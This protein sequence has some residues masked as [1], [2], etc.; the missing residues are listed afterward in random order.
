MSPPEGTAIMSGDVLERLSSMLI[1]PVIEIDDADRAAPLADAL[2]AAGLPCAEVTFRTPAAAA[3]IEA[4]AARHPDLL[5][6][7]GTVLSATQADRAL[8]CGAQF[9]VSPGCNPEVVRHA[10]VMGAVMLPGVCT[11]TEVE[12]ALALGAGVLKFFPAGPVGGPAYLKALTAPYPDVRFVPTGGIDAASL[13]GY[14]AIDQV[15]A[16]GGSWIAPRA[17]ITAGR[18]DLIESA[19]RAAVTAA[20]AARPG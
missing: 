12:A 17:Q 18:F 16:V 9:L 10:Q 19:A 13:P 6:G 1:L 7:A 15:L 20:R 5:L 4:I 2:V 11:P 14:L 3:A 8:S